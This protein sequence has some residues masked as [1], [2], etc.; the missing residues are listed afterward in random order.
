[1]HARVLIYTGH[2]KSNNT[3]SPRV[4]EFDIGRSVTLT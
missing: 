3:Y 4:Q 2:E 1:M